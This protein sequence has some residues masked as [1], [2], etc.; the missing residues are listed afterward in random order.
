[1]KLSMRRFLGVA[2][3]SAAALTATI[4]PATAAVASP[5]TASAI[6]PTINRTDCNENGYLEIHNNEGRDTL[7]FANAGSM[8]VAIYGVNWVES[9]NN[10]VTLQF[11]RNLS[12][13][14]LETVTLQKWSSWNPGHVHEI[15]SIRIY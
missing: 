14:T 5:S 1:M 15:L 12:D 4:V 6:G 10:V 2:A 11:Q 9:G 13:P 8:P 3:V 7:C